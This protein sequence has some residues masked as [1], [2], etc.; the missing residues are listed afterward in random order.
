MIRMKRF[1]QTSM[2]IQLALCA[3]SETNYFSL[4]THGGNEGVCQRELTLLLDAT[5]NVNTTPQAPSQLGKAKRMQIGYVGCVSPDLIIQRIAQTDWTTKFL[6][7]VPTR[8]L[9][10]PSIDHIGLAHLFIFIFAICNYITSP[11]LFCMSF[12]APVQYA[13]TQAL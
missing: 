4:N 12:A 1:N 5:A 9:Q 6:W 11:Q 10:T 2:T 13:A 8:R 3:G 7:I